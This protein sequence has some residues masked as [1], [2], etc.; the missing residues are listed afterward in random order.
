[1]DLDY[2]SSSEDEAATAEKSKQAAQEQKQTNVAKDAELAN[3]TKVT[4]QEKNIFNSIAVSEIMRRR[5]ETAAE[6]EIAGPAAR[7]LAPTDMPPS[8]DVEALMRRRNTILDHEIISAG[9][10]APSKVQT[11]IYNMKR[12]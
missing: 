11:P 5:M 9:P 6:D 4:G 3:K 12:E 8:I 1:M 2:A 7:S 10:T